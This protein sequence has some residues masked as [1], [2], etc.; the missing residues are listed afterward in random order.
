[1]DGGGGWHACGT[2]SRGIGHMMGDAGA[3]PEFE[4]NTLITPDH[5]A[6]QVCSS[7]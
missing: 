4:V 2:N 7:G 5:T 1:M 3:L 6:F